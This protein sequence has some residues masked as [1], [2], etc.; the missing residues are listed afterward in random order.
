MERLSTLALVHAAAGMDHPG[1]QLE[2][3]IR[4]R[5]GKTVDTSGAFLVGELERLDQTLHEPLASVTWDRDLP[6]RTDVTVGDEVSSFTQSTFAAPSGAGQGSAIGQKRSFIGRDTTEIPTMAVD[7][8]KQTVPLTP[9]GLGV[10]YTLPELASAAQLGRPVDQQKIVAL[11]REYQLQ[12]DAQAYL[13]SEITSTYGLINSPLVTAT[14]L[15]DTGTGNSPNWADK[16]SSQIL[17]DMAMMVYAPWAASG[18]AVK[19]NR[20]ALDP[21]NYNLIRIT[22]ATT[23]GS[24]SILQY[25]LESYNSDPNDEPLRVLPLKWL[26]GAGAGGTLMTPGTVNRAIAYNRWEGED[27]QNAFVRFPTTMLQRTPVQYDGLFHKLYYWGRMGACEFVYP[28][29]VAYYDGL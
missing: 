18:F 1:G 15:P 20:L 24:K 11:N 28:E 16:T 17:T 25:F 22:P 14:N 2:R 19:P 13:G 8:D 7:I 6:L 5:D 9:W 29:T 3:P 21:N 27:W 12:T 4:T 26:T 10:S 23:A